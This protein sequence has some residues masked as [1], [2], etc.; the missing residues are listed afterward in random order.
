MAAPSQL[1][2]GNTRAS[3]FLTQDDAKSPATAVCGVFTRHRGTSCDRTPVMNYMDTWRMR[4]CDLLASAYIARCFRAAR[5]KGDATQTVV[6]VSRGAFRR[7]IPGLT[8]GVVLVDIKGELLKRCLQFALPGGWF[9]QLICL[10]YRQNLRQAFPRTVRTF[11]GFVR[12]SK[13]RLLFG[14]VDYFEVALFADRGFYDSSTQ[15]I[16][17][18]HENYAIEFVMNVTRELYAKVDNA[19]LFDELYAYGPP[20]SELL[21]RFTLE[22]GGVRPM[23]MPRLARM[24][25]DVDFQK[26]LATVDR[27]DFRKSILLLAF[28]GVEYLAPI[29]FTATLMAIASLG[30]R[31]AARPIVKFKNAGAAKVA[32]RQ[33]G[34]LRDRFEWVYDGSVEALVWRAGFTVV[35]NS[36]SF[37]EALLGPTIVIMPA[38]L[39]ALHD[40]NLLQETA[41]SIGRLVGPLETVV[42]AHTP[43]EIGQIMA[44]LDG[45]NFRELMIR[46]RAARKA[47]VRNKFFLTGSR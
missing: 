29:C 26:R 2:W 4:L 44:R 15:V 40:D 18:F 19:F 7:D 16:A 42:F 23:V 35:F 28:A 47:I 41:A 1:Q 13:A 17:V 22:K 30:E 21:A 27:P 39:D 32:L 10:D 6:V 43:G 11:V 36:I 12:T 9:E 31:G 33:A 8:Q 46:E 20:A 24:Q 25:D 5:R 3:V 38:Y 37:Y 14:G 45:K 34:R